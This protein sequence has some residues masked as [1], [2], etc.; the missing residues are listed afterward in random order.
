[1]DKK[2]AKK[3]WTLKRIATFGGIAIF[4]VFHSLSIFVCGQTLKLVSRER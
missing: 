2:I 1:M 3:I 4:V